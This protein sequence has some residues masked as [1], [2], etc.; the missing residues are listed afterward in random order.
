LF[1]STH[2]EIIYTWWGR[3]I[4]FHAIVGDVNVML[5]LWSTLHS[6]VSGWRSYIS[7]MTLTMASSKLEIRNDKTEVDE[8]EP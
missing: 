1:E 2:I 3:V 8:H 6:N 4:V 5:V 7:L